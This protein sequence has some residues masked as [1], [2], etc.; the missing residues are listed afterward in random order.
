MREALQQGRTPIIITRNSMERTL[1]VL[2]AHVCKMVQELLDV[3]IFYD[4]MVAKD[5][6]EVGGADGMSKFENSH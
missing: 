4:K 2:E 1:L 3:K 5:A 6:T